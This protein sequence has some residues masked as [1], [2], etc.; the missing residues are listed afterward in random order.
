MYTGIV[1]FKYI[2]LFKNINFLLILIW[3]RKKFFKIKKLSKFV[4]ILIFSKK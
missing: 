1:K 4:K 2:F 3:R